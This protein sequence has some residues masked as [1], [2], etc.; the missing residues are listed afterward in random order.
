M[1]K[2]FSLH[3]YCILGIILSIFALSSSCNNNPYGKFP[4]GK[5]FLAASSGDPR[6]L[7][8]VRVSDTASNAIAS[9]IHDTPYQYHYLKRPLQV[10]PSMATAMPERRTVTYRG[11]F[12][13][14]FRFSIKQ[15]LRYHD[16]VCFKDGK[17]REILIDDIIFSMKRAADTSQDA[18]GYPLLTGRIQD[19]DRFSDEIAELHQS[20]EDDS[21]KRQEKVREFYRTEI[22]GIRKID[23]YTLELILTQDY[24]QILYFFTLSVGSPV[25]EECFFY[26]N[27]RDGRPTYDRHP[28][29]SGPFYIKEWHPKH[30]IILERN[31]SYRKD[32]F[33][34]SQGNPGDESNGM[35]RDAGKSLPLVDAFHF[36]NVEAG[37]TIWTLFEQGYLDRAGIPREVFNQVIQ[38]QS[39]SS[40]YKEKGIRLEKD[41]DV[42]TYWWYFNMKDSMLGKNRSLRQAI[43]LAVDRKEIIR[44]FYNGRGVVAHSMLPPALEGY[45]D[46][47][48]NPYSD[49]NL[50]KAKQKLKEAGFPGGIDP[51]TGKPLKISLILV[52]SQGA[53]SLYRSYID[54]LAKINIELEVQ[55]LDWPTVLEKKNAKSFQMIHGGWHADYPDPQNFFQLL[56]G[57]NASGTY[58]ENSYKNPEFDRLYEKMRNMEPGPKRVK[59]IRRMN[60]IVAGDAPVVFLFHPM[61]YGLSHQWVAGIRPHPINTN[62]LK[63]RNLD[64]ELRSRLAKEW[65]KPPWWAYILVSGI[66]I[67]LLTLAFLAIRSYR[68]MTF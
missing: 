32:D 19:F 18:F 36:Y 48:R 41:V 23:D 42:A 47:F 20:I 28:V 51:A 53:T 65:N 10:I 63:Y 38:D 39:L 12:F 9:N 3:R 50:E 66:M 26:Y 40:E 21:G 68:K 8:P 62:Q 15:G 17:G 27:G 25:P 59:I 67:L 43:S 5:V 30:R 24:P 34:P 4:E 13:P 55:Q 46:D 49:F 1:L 16:D 33:Y 6:T 52:A 7:D 45:A 57:P 60:E 56:Y 37:P 44:K 35:L 58:N 29:A 54:Q 14:A 2:H 22:D 64:P 31:P 11:R 61:S